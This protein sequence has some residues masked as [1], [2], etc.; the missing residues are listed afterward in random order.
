MTLHTCTPLFTFASPPDLASSPRSTVPLRFSC[1][2]CM[3]IFI[4]THILQVGEN[5]QCFTPSPTLP[6]TVPHFLSLFLS[7]YNSPAVYVMWIFESRSW[8]WEKKGCSSSSFW[9]WLVSLDMRISPVSSAFLNMAWF[10][11][12]VTSSDSTASTP[13]CLYPSFVTQLTPTPLCPH[14]TLSTHPLCWCVSRLV[15]Y[16]GCYETC[17]SKPCIHNFWQPSIARVARP[18]CKGTFS[19]KWSVHDSFWS[20]LTHFALIPPLSLIWGRPHSCQ[21]SV[22]SSELTEPS[23]WATWMI[24]PNIP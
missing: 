7:F 9:I 22:W 4:S 14:T 11:S 16:L 8:I 5:M 20:A 23:P 24:F 13:H 18:Q 10:C 6:P 21:P 2:M 1:R 12:F 15:R 17:I 19:F 3:F